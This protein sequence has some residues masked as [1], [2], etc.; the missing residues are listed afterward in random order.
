VCYD[1]HAVSV[2]GAAIES[3]MKETRFGTDGESPCNLFVVH[4]AEAQGMHA[5]T[6]SLNELEVY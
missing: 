1:P 5:L 4:E 2:L 3:A 6:Q